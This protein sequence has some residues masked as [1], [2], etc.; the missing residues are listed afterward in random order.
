MF[1]VSLCSIKFQLGTK[2]ISDNVY[3]TY[4]I[5]NNSVPETIRKYVTLVFQILNTIIIVVIAI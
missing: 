2:F 5:P 1:H 4:S 3:L